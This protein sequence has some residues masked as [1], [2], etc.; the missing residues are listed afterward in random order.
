MG[1]EN[2]AEENKNMDVKGEDKSEAEKRTQSR[3][4]KIGG[5]RCGRRNEKEIQS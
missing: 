5:K 3:E 4:V 2:G 1:E